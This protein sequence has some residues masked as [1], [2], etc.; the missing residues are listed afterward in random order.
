MGHAR[1]M[2][3]RDDRRLGRDADRARRQEERGA[4]RRRRRTNRVNGD[5]ADLRRVIAG[6]LGFDRRS[7]SIDIEIGVDQ[8]GLVETGRRI[9]FAVWRILRKGAGRDQLGKCVLRRALDA[10]H[11]R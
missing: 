7:R 9:G 11:F 1:I 2:A 5:V 3:R 4:R 6:E 8:I 10:M